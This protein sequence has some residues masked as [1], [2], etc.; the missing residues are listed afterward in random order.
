MWLAEA[1]AE[2]V[3]ARRSPSG[4]SCILSHQ[5]TILSHGRKPLGRREGRRTRS[6]GAEEEEDKQSS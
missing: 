3:A 1:V 6:L 5:R 4:N 2:V